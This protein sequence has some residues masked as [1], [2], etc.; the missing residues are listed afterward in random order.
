MEQI[1]V[2]LS[3][4]ALATMAV[5]QLSKAIEMARMTEA[6]L[7]LENIR[8]AELLYHTEYNT[9]T[10]NLSRLVAQV[11]S[12]GSKA[13]YF[14]Y[15]VASAGS[16]AFVVTATRKTAGAEGKTPNSAEGY[17]VTL[18]HDGARTTLTGGP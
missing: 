4:G 8:T 10:A 11:P 1:L 5:P 7:M 2:A 16:S 13:H 15:A 12:D 17:T 18:N 3:A 14:R 9:Y 6:Y